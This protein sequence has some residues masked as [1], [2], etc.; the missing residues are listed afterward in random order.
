METTKELCN[1]C[2]SCKGKPNTKD[3]QIGI[4]IYICPKCKGV[5]P[6]KS[7]IYRCLHCGN[8]FDNHESITVHLFENF[9]ISDSRFKKEVE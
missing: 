1:L 9:V 2:L 6:R 7:G 3:N 5:K 8:F 4:F